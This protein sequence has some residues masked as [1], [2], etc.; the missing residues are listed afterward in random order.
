MERYRP[1]SWPRRGLIPGTRRR[2]RSSSNTTDDGCTYRRSIQ[3]FLGSSARLCNERSLFEGWIGGW[4]PS[5]PRSPPR[6][7]S[8]DNSPLHY[9]NQERAIR[10]KISTPHRIKEEEVLHALRRIRQSG[11]LSSDGE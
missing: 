6:Y 9:S 11:D 5:S 10:K 1:P 2:S 7:L 4:I 3:I 8:R